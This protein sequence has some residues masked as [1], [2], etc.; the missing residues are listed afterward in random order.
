MLQ[1]ATQVLG[2]EVS[3]TDNL[4]ETGLNSILATQFVWLAS[5]ARISLSVTTLFSFPTISS[6]VAELEQSEH[7][8]E[9]EEVEVVSG[10]RIP[11]TYAESSLYQSLTAFHPSS[12]PTP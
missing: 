11:L 3:P 7:K 6:L 2:H 8:E 10:E 5:Q 4:L 1:I 9:S 12:P